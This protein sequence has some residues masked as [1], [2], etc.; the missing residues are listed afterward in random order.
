MRY[1]HRL[2]L[3]VPFILIFTGCQTPAKVVKVNETGSGNA[4]K[5]GVNQ[6]FYYAL[7]KTAYEIRIFGTLHKT[8][9]GRLAGFSHLL[10]YP[11]DKDLQSGNKLIIDSF[12]VKAKTRPD[13]DKLYFVTLPP[14]DQVF[15]ELTYHLSMG[16]N[17]GL[18]GLNTRG[19][20]LKKR[21]LP[22]SM[23]Q[24][25]IE[26]PLSST[27]GGGK[28]PQKQ[29]FDRKTLENG[30]E[31]L[32]SKNDELIYKLKR[33]GQDSLFRQDSLIKTKVDALGQKAESYHGKIK[34]L[35]QLFETYRQAD[36]GEKARKFSDIMHKLIE[37]KT[38]LTGGKSDMSYQGAEVEAMIAGID[39]MLTNYLKPF[40]EKMLT[41]NLSWSFEVTPDVEQ[42]VFQMGL[43][44]GEEGTYFWEKQQQ[45][46]QYTA[47][48][49]VAFQTDQ[50]PGIQSFERQKV[51]SAEEQKPNGL[52]YNLPAHGT[53]HITLTGNNR[54]REQPVGHSSVVLP[55]LGDVATLPTLNF[56]T[57]YSLD[58]FYGT[59]QGIQYPKDK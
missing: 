49:N 53:M 52:F 22:F 41:K 14:D 12:R 1:L 50:K 16:P 35:K 4:L 28:K 44:K 36:L 33:L 56:N 18:A 8:Y 39:E 34:E 46:R 48:M 13:Y 30:L 7:P 32:L 26:I 54:S 45:E 15:S 2:L 5:E 21:S 9:S 10:K 57:G 37:L 31:D 59:L 23:Q 29:S 20:P 19:K 47:S 11:T 58:P 6:G 38:G 27:Q 25:P 17:G 3:T 43:R 40:Q 42:Q 51:K 55:Q 24:R